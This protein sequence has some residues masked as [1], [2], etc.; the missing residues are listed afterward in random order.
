MIDPDEQQGP[1]QF[2]I[3]RLQQSDPSI[4]PGQPIP[5]KKITDGFAAMRGG[6][7]GDDNSG[8]GGGRNDDDALMPELLVPGF[9]VEVEPTPMMGFGAAAEMLAVPV[10]AEDERDANE[11]IQR[12]DRNRDG[13]LSGDEI[14]S[15]FSGNP[16]DFDRNRDGKLT[17]S[18]LAVRSAR[19]RE[20]REESRRDD[21]RRRNRGE[22]AS[23]EKRR[24]IA[25]GDRAVS[26]S[27]AIDIDLD[28]RLEPIE[29]T[30]AVAH[31]TNV[32]AT[33]A[34]HA[35]DGIRDGIGADGQSTRVA[36]NVNGHG[37]LSASAMMAS[38]AVASTRP[39]GL[40]SIMTAGAFAHRP[41][42]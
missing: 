31:K 23:V 2:I 7:G 27:G 29:A 20:T 16:L 10:T 32:V 21:E 9:G 18:E 38:N 22:E 14:S 25:G 36:R 12:F 41:R 28:E 15:R 5:L 3:Q 11:M 30:R 33:L 4:K 17:A 1:A 35:G 24:N 42:Q 34:S 19:R 26:N 6:Q 37:H 39:T 40:R 8:R 13:V